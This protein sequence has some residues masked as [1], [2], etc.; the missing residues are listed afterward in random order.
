MS[1]NPGATVYPVLLSN[2][3]R[4]YVSQDIVHGKLGTLIGKFPQNQEFI[5]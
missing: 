3:L 5:H 4:C 1:N 2:R